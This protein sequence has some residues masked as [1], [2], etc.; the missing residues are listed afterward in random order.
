MSE[1]LHS[2]AE[3]A[4][5]RV[6]IEIPALTGLRGVA[7]LWVLLFHTWQTAG[8]PRIEWL[9]VP[10]WHV[11][12]AGW[13][14]VDLFFVL[15]GFLLGAPFARAV[16]DG[17]PRPDLG[18]F[19]RRRIGRVVPAY[20]GQL[21]VLAGLAW[22]VDGSWPLTLWE[23]LAQFTLTENL[24]PVFQESL[25]PVY[26]SLPV[27]W[28]FYVLLPLLVLLFR[29]LKPWQVFAMVIVFSV[30]WRFACLGAIEHWGE[31]GIRFYTTIL[32]LPSR[33]D[34]FFA[35]I[36][37][38]LAVGKARVA[39]PRVAMLAGMALVLVMAALLSGVGDFIGEAK[40][41]WVVLCYSVLAVAFGLIVAG[42][43]S[44]G[45]VARVLFA[46][47]PLR[48]AGVIS[49][50]LYL[51]HFPILGWLREAGWAGRD[52]GF[53][54]SLGSALLATVVVSALSWRLLERPFHTPPRPPEKA[55]AA[56]ARE[57]P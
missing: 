4:G 25:N 32:Q 29:R 22:W 56:P 20:W 8:A 23:T 40:L 6:R 46:N 15:S 1:S 55:P 57:A 35:G 3:A 36:L 2:S 39:R 37:A 54:V 49:Y 30:A 47:P 45:K 38:G 48:A 19:W 5:E 53:A 14:G 44:G 10:V 17:L 18:R 33:L 16:H 31:D 51:W 21:L 42:A 34:E 52:A 50:S 11:L 13:M 26:W 28:D 7:A 9:G 43:A 24:L 27:E 12:S 41:P